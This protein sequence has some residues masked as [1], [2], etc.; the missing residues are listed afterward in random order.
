[1]LVINITNNII[2][3][4]PLWY[5]INDIIIIIINII[6][7]F[8]AFLFICTV[9]H[10]EYPSYS[11]SNIIA[12]Q[13]CLAI[14]LIS[15]SILLNNCYALISDFRGIGYNDSFCIVRGTIYSILFVVLYTSLCLKA[16][17]R[18]RCIVYRIRSV[19]RSYKSLLIL[20]L[21]QW[22]IITIL[23]L[24]IILT[25]GVDYDWGS[26]LCLVTINKPWQFIFL[27]MLF[28]L[29]LLSKPNQVNQSDTGSE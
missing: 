22:I 12:C 5:F 1:M 16:F 4:Y 15:S 2:N 3:S 19:S 25:K 18:L 26:H 13:T 21:I 17:N 28:I 14:G 8:I 24:P 11:I 6:G 29:L 7:I 10:L 27:S 20:T 23:I 9:I